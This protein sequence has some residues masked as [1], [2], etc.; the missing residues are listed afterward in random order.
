MHPEQDQAAIVVEADEKRRVR[1]R[2]E[3]ALHSWETSTGHSQIRRSITRCLVGGRLVWSCVRAKVEA[4][5]QA[6]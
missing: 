2:E 4:N 1:S 3:A 5:L 6:R